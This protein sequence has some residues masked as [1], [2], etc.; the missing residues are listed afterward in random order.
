[1]NGAACVKDA[2]TLLH[3]VLSSNRFLVLRYDASALF[4]NSNCYQEHRSFT[5]LNPLD[6]T[7]YQNDTLLIH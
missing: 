5:E 7:R 6:K 2:R 3:R 1:M 4:L